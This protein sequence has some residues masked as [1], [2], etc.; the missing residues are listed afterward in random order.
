MARVLYVPNSQAHVKHHPLLSL[1]I[2]YAHVFRS[3]MQ[4]LGRAQKKPPT[5]SILF[6]A[7]SSS[8]TASFKITSSVV[9]IEGY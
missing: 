4:S 9:V 8:P 2:Q 3:A 1:A 5:Y 6:S 7:H